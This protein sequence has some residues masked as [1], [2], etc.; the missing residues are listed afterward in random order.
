ME[1]NHRESIQ[2]NQVNKII[3]YCYILNVLLECITELQYS[4]FS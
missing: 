3:D 2:G 1:S 4:L